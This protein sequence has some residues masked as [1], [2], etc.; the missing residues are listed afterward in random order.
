MDRLVTLS[1][2]ALAA[3]HVTPA[4]VLFR[5]ALTQRLYAVP[6]SGDV[7]LLLIHRG[8]LFLAVLAATLVAAVHLPSRRLATI[9]VAISM[10]PFLWLYVRG[11][12]PP[13]LRTIFVADLIG[14][15]PLAVV[16]WNA[17]RP[18]VNP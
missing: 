2:L 14:L 3:I 1:W 17:W 9:V 10:L 4:M 12:S 11:G 13:G 5:P 8:A 6:P 16:V 7:G 15:V 18:A